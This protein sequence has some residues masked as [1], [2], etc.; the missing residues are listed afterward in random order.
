MEASYNHN[1][2]YQCMK[3]SKTKYAFKVFFSANFMLLSFPNVLLTIH[4][5]LLLFH[6]FQ[7]YRMTTE[8]H[9]AD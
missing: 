2:V 3:L 6:V 9:T 4:S 1:T 7:K 8:R 5:V